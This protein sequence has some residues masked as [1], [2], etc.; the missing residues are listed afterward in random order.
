[1]T[2]S[3]PIIDQIEKDIERTNAEHEFFQKED[4]KDILKDVLLV[5]AENNLD[6]EYVQG[7]NE[8]AALILLVLYQESLP[9][10][11]TSNEKIISSYQTIN[12]L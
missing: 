11:T 3:I 12:I 5:W 9:N 8:I 7:M 10:S 6:T 1:M 4:T 2:I